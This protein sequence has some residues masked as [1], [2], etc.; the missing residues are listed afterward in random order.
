MS[1]KKQFSKYIFNVVLFMENNGKNWQNI[2]VVL[3]VLIFL[4][5]NKFKAK[6]H[7]T[8]KNQCSSN[9]KKHTYIYC[10]LKFIKLICYQRTSNLK[11]SGV[12]LS[13]YYKMLKICSFQI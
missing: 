8:T 10:K 13:I 11:S 2:I 4:C 6:I 12:N 3:S 5:D 9:F 7:T 1:I